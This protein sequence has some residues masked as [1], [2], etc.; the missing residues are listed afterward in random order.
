M[1]TRSQSDQKSSEVAQMTQPLQAQEFT[2]TL[3]P[4]RSLV[5]KKYVVNISKVKQDGDG[6]Y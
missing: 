5:M 3:R 6:Y 1:A 4:K 2:P